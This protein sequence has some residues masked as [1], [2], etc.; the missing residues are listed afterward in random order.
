MTIGLDESGTDPEPSQVIQS[1]RVKVTPAV[2]TTHIGSNMGRTAGP[3]LACSH[4]LQPGLRPLTARS[5]STDRHG[6][7]ASPAQLGRP[8]SMRVSAMGS[9][10]GIAQPTRPRQH[11]VRPQPPTPP[12]PLQSRWRLPRGAE[13]RCLRGP[14]RRGTGSPVGRQRASRSRLLRDFWASRRRFQRQTGSWRESGA[15]ARHRAFPRPS[16][17]RRSSPGL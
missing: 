5:T 9:P 7:A 10:T 3:L 8:V 17:T 12:R 14:R 6:A 16:R 11:R 13:Q 1:G 4:G 2:S 15:S